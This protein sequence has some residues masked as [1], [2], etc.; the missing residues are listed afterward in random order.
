MCNTKV[1]KQVL[2]M[3][4]NPNTRRQYHGIWHNLK[5]YYEFYADVT[6]EQSNIDVS[7]FMFDCLSTIYGEYI[8]YPLESK[9]ENPRREHYKIEKKWKMDTEYGKARYD[10]LLKMIGYCD[11]RI[12]NI[13]DESLISRV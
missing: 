3:I 12:E 10:L 13:N 7:H 9:L 5:F 1:I 11:L 2:E 8:P 6:P 4:K